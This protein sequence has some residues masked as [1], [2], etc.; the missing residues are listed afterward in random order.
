MKLS[1]IGFLKAPLILQG[2]S[3]FSPSLGYFLTCLRLGF[4]RSSCEENYNFLLT[5]ILIY[6]FNLCFLVTYPLIFFFTLDSMED[7]SIS[8]FS[9]IFVLLVKEVSTTSCGKDTFSRVRKSEEK[10]NS[11]NPWLNFPNSFYINTL[12]MINAMLTIWKFIHPSS[13]F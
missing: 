11:C 7:I 12:M 5:N 3:L 9:N 2:I 4:L 8:K 10:I 1:R 13:C 6:T